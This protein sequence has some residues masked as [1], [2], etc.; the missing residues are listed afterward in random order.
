MFKCL[1]TIIIMLRGVIECIKAFIDEAPEI[2]TD[3]REDPETAPVQTYNEIASQLKE[4]QAIVEIEP[5]QIEIGNIEQQRERF[6]NRND[7]FVVA[8]DYTKILDWIVTARK[9]IHDLKAI[10]E[11]QNWV[12]TENHNTVCGLHHSLCHE[13][14]GLVFTATNGADYFKECACMGSEKTCN[15][16]GCGSAQHCHMHK[17]PVI[18]SVTV[19]EILRDFLQV[20]TTDAKL[21][22]KELAAKKINVRAKLCT[23]ELKFKRLDPKYKLSKY[24]NEQIEYLKT[25]MESTNDRRK[26]ELGKMIEI[27]EDAC[28][29]VDQTFST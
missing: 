9:N 4:I 15:I 22:I 5:D 19:Q 26:Q 6:E 25:C 3:L 20:E 29:R 16:C 24:F 2:V 13:S 21:I 1:G 8:T 11:I 18:D 23:E 17:R 12:E 27:Y 14:C 7:I 10:V 28:I